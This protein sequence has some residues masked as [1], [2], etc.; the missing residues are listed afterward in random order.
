MKPFFQFRKKYAC[1][2]KSPNL[3]KKRKAYLVCEFE[4]VLKKSAK[5]NAKKKSFIFMNSNIF[6]KKKRHNI[7]EFKNNPAIFVTLT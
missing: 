6:W 1:I 7:Y 3:Y 5:F 4:L 2:F